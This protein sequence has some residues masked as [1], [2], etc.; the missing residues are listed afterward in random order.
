V[1]AVVAS[2]ASRLVASGG[3]LTIRSASPVVARILDITWLADRV[4]VL[5]QEAGPSTE[6]GLWHDLGPALGTRLTVS[7]SE[8]FDFAFVLE[9][10]RRRRIDRLE[11]AQQVVY[12]W[13]PKGR[14]TQNGGP[15]A[16]DAARHLA[17]V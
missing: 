16:P 1:G 4:V 5:A 14:R 13:R 15:D 9:Q 6:A 7:P 12:R 8:S 17:G 2:A 3:R 11:V 10:A